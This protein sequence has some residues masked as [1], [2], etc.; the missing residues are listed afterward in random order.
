MPKR[1]LKEKRDIKNNPIK[2]FS[3]EIIYGGLDGIITTFAVIAGFTGAQSENT[4]V[5][6]L[7]TVL[8]FSFANLFSDAA[9]MAL[10]NFLSERTEIQ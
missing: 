2:R 3:R 5:Y 7:S 9:S 4:K 10:G 1:Y 6:A 8:L